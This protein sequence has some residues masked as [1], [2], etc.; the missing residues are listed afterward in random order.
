[1]EGIG[2]KVL[3]FVKARVKESDASDEEQTAVLQRAADEAARGT[4]HLSETAS[5]NRGR[6]QP[7]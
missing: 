3:D 4:S 5:E 1:M 2:G 6:R 7:S